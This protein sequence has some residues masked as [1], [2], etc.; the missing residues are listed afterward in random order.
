M[1]Y[2]IIKLGTEVVVSDP[3]YTIPTWCQ[4]IVKNVLPGNYHSFLK[5]T[6]ANDWGIRNSVLLV[7]HED[8]MDTKKKWF[9]HGG[10]IGVDSGQAGIF[11]SESYR[12]DEVAEQIGEGEYGS[13]PLHRSESGDIWYEKMCSRTLGESGWGHYPEGV[14][15]CSGIG[16]GS[17]QLRVARH[18][19]KIVGLAIDYLM[20]NRLN[21]N[22]YK[23]EVFS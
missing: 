5:K 9:H 2:N 6:D 1:S 10:V 20:E 16:D 15:S 4:V 19:G 23:E 21:L 8:H 13:F 17:Y 7:I 18:K 22:F 11:S 12:S 14:V 3:C